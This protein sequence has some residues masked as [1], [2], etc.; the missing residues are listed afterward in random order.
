MKILNET[1]FKTPMNKITS[2]EREVDKISEKYFFNTMSRLTAQEGINELA[3]VFG[4][5]VA[6][7]A[8]NEELFNADIQDISNAFKVGLKAGF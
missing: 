3:R 7:A 6:Q 1:V 5:L 8:I 2:F 4:Y